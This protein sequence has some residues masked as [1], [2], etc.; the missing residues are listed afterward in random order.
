M[1]HVPGRCNRPGRL[2]HIDGAGVELINDFYLSSQVESDV[3]E[4]LGPSHLW[5]RD[6]INEDDSKP[7]DRVLVK[8][9]TLLSDVKNLQ[10]PRRQRLIYLIRPTDKEPL[11]LFVE[12]DV[13]KRRVLRDTAG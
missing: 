8:T 4:K 12:K 2:S 13:P 9:F 7:E 5:D 3:E 11:L 6:L 10:P 1:P